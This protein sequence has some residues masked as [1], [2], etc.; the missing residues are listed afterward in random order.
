MSQPRKNISRV[1]LNGFS[2]PSAIREASTSVE[3]L[4]FDPGKDIEISDWADQNVF[5]NPVSD[6]E[7]LEKWG[8]ISHATAGKNLEDLYLSLS[9][10]STVRSVLQFRNGVVD[11]VD[12]QSLDPEIGEFHINHK[13]GLLELYSP[14][15]KLR[16]NL[17]RSL[18]DFCGENSVSELF[19]SK[20]ALRSLME[21]AIEVTSISLTGLGNPFFSDATFSG[22]D[23]VNSK[24]C[25][26]LL[27]SGEIKSFRAK[28]QTAGSS[29]DA[30]SPPLAASVSGS[31]CKLSFYAR[32]SPVSQGDIEDFIQRV[33]NIASVREPL[34]PAV[35]PLAENMQRARS[36][37]ARKKS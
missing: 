20:D 5:T 12:Q 18:K 37:Q 32:Q 16:T 7:A 28:Y 10:R 35:K 8:I 14:N 36:R 34:A 3:I 11:R 2:F 17:V 27:V 4:K 9:F 19:L 15:P 29:N 24:T 13:A 31:K 6:E 21:E 26:E 23:P 33:S 22:T 1:E 25:K 30:S